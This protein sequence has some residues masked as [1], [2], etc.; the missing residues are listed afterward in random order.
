[1]VQSSIVIPVN[2]STPTNKRKP[3]DDEQEIKAEDTEG[4]QAKRPRLEVSE[5]GKSRNKRLFGVLLGT[6]NKFKDDTEQTSEVDKNR[7]EINRKLQD[8]LYLEKKAV[9]EKMEARKL[10]KERL[11]QLKREEVDKMIAE[12]KELQDVQQQ[13]ILA[14]FL[15]TATEPTLYYL[16]N[17]LTE[18][19]SKLLD[20]QAQDA[21]IALKSFEERKEGYTGES[22]E[23]DKLSDNED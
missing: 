15:K 5:A 1:M 9:A 22:R 6:L 4:E 21:L 17:K 11:E 2:H 23:E 18:G 13:K 19:M 12:K 16:P 14:N 10:E 20:T 8:K 7:R 3:E